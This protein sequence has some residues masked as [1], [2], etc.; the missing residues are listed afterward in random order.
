MSMFTKI[1]EMPL[2]DLDSAGLTIA[3]QEEV[4]A[5]QALFDFE[6][7]YRAIG[8]AT[9]LHAKQTRANRGNLPRTPYIEHPL[10]NA[11]RLL[12]W[13]CFDQDIIIATILHDTVEDGAHRICRGAYGL[14]PRDMTAAEMRVTAFG[15]ITDEFGP[16]V[17]RL[18][19][20]VTNGFLPGGET[21]EEKRKI[22]AEHVRKVISDPGVFLVKFADF[23]DNASGLYH[24]DIK[25]NRD[26]VIHL[27]QKYLPVV[28]IFEEEYRRIGH[29][30]PINE[31]AKREIERHLKD[32][33]RR[34]TQIV[35]RI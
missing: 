10:R 1:R 17:L 35:E 25:D 12:R 16:E 26:K 18:V 23:V 11:N 13:G 14:S 27:A 31:L 32:T 9:Y 22:Y 4:R 33:R 5:H 7:V 29:L 20:A 30:L 8:V 6:T 15:Y 24:N 21:P 34:L 28:D 2:K 19:T 3:L